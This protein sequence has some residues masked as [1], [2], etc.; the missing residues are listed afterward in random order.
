MGSNSTAS[1]NALACS[2]TRNSWLMLQKLYVLWFR[3]CPSLIFAVHGIYFGSK[4]KDLRDALIYPRSA[5]FFGVWTCSQS[6]RPKKDQAFLSQ[7]QPW[8][9]SATQIPCGVGKPGWFQQD[10][11]KKTT[12]HQAKCQIAA[13]ATVLAGCVAWCGHDS[14]HHVPTRAEDYKTTTN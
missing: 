14:V 6:N 12:K 2:P 5:E 4:K 13:A 9:P 11:V 1:S 8:A 7:S 10:F 3:L